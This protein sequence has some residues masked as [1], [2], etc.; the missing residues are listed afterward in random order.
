[1]AWNN[2]YSSIGNY[3]TGNGYIN[4]YNNNCIPSTGYNTV[5]STSTSSGTGYGISGSNSLYN[6]Y[7]SLPDMSY[8]TYSLLPTYSVYSN[9]RSLPNTYTTNGNSDLET[10]S[11]PYTH[12]NYGSYGSQGS[13]DSLNYLHT[14]PGFQRSR[15]VVAADDVSGMKKSSPSSISVSS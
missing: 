6:S 3:G 4:C 5:P 2:G 11:L 14:F 10:Y 13:V 7:S 8:K 9:L 12:S 1:M 15:K